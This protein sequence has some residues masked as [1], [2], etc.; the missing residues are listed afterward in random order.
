MTPALV[1]CTI[2]FVSL[3]IALVN[4]SHVSAPALSSAQAKAGSVQA[5]LQSLAADL[6]LPSHKVVA[7]IS[8]PRD[9]SY[10]RNK[11]PHLQKLLLQERSRLARTWLRENRLHLSQLLR[12]HRLIERA[13]PTLSVRVEFHVLMTFLSL[14]AML[15]AAEVAVYVGGPFAAR[16]FGMNALTG[17]AQ[18]SETIA[19]TGQLLNPSQRAVIRSNW[20]Q[21]SN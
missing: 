13:N 7:G 19:D 1:I 20:A 2:L 11:A 12:L 21:A 3:V 15:L 8:D 4:W 5:E 17:F 10:I 9:L 6:E 16:G 14:Q 18:L